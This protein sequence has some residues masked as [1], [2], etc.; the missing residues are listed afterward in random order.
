[1]SNEETEKSEGAT[2]ESVSAIPPAMDP[3]RK[4]TLIVLGICSVLITWYLVADRHTPFTSQ[5]RVHAL[6]VPIAAQV[7][8]TVTDVF[9]RNNQFVKEGEELFRVDPERFRLAVETAEANLQS[10]RQATG[11]SK[12]NID[13]ADSAVGSAIA[14]QTRSQQDYERMRGIKEEDP[15]AISVRRLEAAE[16]TFAISIQQVAAAR[17]NLEKARQDFGKEGEENVRILQAQA[18]LSQ[19]RLDLERTSIRA[20]TDGLVTDV[21]V[22]RGNFASTGAPQMTFLAIHNVWVQADF[23]EN[24]L[25]HIKPGAEVEIAF[26]ALPGRI[27][28]GSVRSIGFGVAVDTAALGA[29]PTIENNRQWLRDA[30]RFP[31][32]VDVEDL[33]SGKISAVRVGSQASVMV[34]AGDSWILNSIAWIYVRAASILSYAY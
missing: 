31:V 6:V 4:W 17:A 30:Q 20:P 10:A 29:L 32:V 8:A 23:T 18:A 1:M 16:A 34:Y 15:G 26:D 28:Q 11:A 24:N 13:A 5:A 33:G 9:V 12:A 2:E 19:A 7:S 22:D 27:F 21:R 25:G 14:N 3:V